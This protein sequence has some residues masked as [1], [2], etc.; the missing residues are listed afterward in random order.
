[1]VLYPQEIEDVKK[2]EYENKLWWELDK[3]ATYEARHA[4]VNTKEER[5][6]KAIAAENMMKH[7]EKPNKKWCREKYE[8]EKAGE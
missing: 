8:S 5:Y 1:M 7:L 6:K 4:P 3:I 2:T